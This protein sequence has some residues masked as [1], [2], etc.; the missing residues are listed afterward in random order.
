MKTLLSVCFILVNIVILTCRKCPVHP[1]PTVDVLYSDWGTFAGIEPQDTFVFNVSQNGGCGISTKDTVRC[2][3]Y[4]EVRISY[5]LTI[6]D[7]FGVM[8][9]VFSLAEREVWAIDIQKFESMSMETQY[10]EHVYSKS[11]LKDGLLFIM[12]DRF[13][14]T[15]LPPYVKVIW[16]DL[17]VVGIKEKPVD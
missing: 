11:E 12:I 8:E 5:Q 2:S 13:A 10:I 16:S 6:S 4:D 1:T 17:R 14:Q 9:I 15:N 7:S 3:K